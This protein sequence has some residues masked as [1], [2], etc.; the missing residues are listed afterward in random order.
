M[1]SLMR[2]PCQQ[3]R[4]V[5]MFPH[6][7]DLADGMQDPRRGPVFG[8]FVERPISAVFVTLCVLLIGAQIYFRVRRPKD[9]PTIPTIAGEEARAAE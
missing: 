2:M 4:D 9:L 6:A 8:V 5:G 7:K 1:L 3:G